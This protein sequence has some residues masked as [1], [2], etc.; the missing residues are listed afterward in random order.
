MIKTAYILP[1]GDELRNG[2]VLDTDSPMLMQALLRLNNNCRICRCGVV[3]D[4]MM[5][6]TEEIHN[7]TEAK[8]DLIILIGGS[9][10]GHLHSDL[11]GKD[12]THAGMESLLERSTAISLYGKNG[13]MW[14][15]LVCGYIGSTLV[16]NVPGPY[17]EAKAAIAAFCAVME[18]D[19]VPEIEALNH[20]MA[21]AVAACYEKKYAGN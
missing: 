1:T 12:Y 13:H 16:V 14:S 8:A 2:T 5:A 21:Q 11:L 18:E 15:R 7:C 10:S 3:S 6:I 20:A 19:P 4:S 17:V 9:G